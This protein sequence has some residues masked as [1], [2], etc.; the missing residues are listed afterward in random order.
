MRL[1][2]NFGGQ[3]DMSQPVNAEVIKIIFS[4]IQF[5]SASEIFD[6]SLKFVPTQGSY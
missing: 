1:Y 6:T 2:V 3:K 5:K 4:K